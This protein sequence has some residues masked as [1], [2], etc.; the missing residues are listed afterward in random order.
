MTSLDTLARSASAAVHESVA[1]IPTPAAP[2]GVA[3]GAAAAW[4]MAR[5]AAA[6][7]AAGLAVVATLVVLPST[8][9]TPTDTAGVTT[10]IP[11]TVSTT[12]PAP[13][14]TVP[15][16]DSSPTPPVVEPGGGAA[17][18]STTTTST[19]TIPVDTEAP[20][21]EI[22][23]PKDGEHFDTTSVTFTGITEPGVTL[24][25]SGK[26]SVPV[27]SSGEWAIDLVLGPGANGV[28]FVATDDA[29]NA[30]Q[31]RLTVHYD[32]PVE[33]T[34]TTKAEKG[35]EFSA[36]QKYGSCAE[37]VPYDEFWGTGKPGS[38]IT[39]SSEF[40]SGSTTVSESGE[41][42]L[43][44][45]FPAAPFGKVFTVKVTDEFGNKKVFEF[46][47]NYSG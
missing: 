23:S 19:T 31:A 35:W 15:D 36:F 41:Y 46:V 24:V 26:F 7:A 2:A 28:V 3:A 45:E 10:T 16:R 40:G 33:T 5:Y 43:R 44:I 6:G 13:S 42:W 29:G 12:V 14:T 18:T 39:V 27:T 4:R 30:T 34:T 37:P 20:I 17:T 47:S 8:E 9:E 22:A 11:T 25:A 1:E 21:L 32:A 38:T